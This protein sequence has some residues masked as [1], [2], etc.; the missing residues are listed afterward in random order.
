MLRLD[1]IRTASSVLAAL[2][3]DVDPKPNTYWI[4]GQP[5]VVNW[6]D[7]NFYV[8]NIT[9]GEN[10][11]ALEKLPSVQSKLVTTVSS[12][13]PE[14]RLPRPATSD[15]DLPCTEVE[16]VNMA[17]NA[18]AFHVHLRLFDIS[19][20]DAPES[21][22]VVAYWD[23]NYITLLPLE[24]RILRVSYF[25]ITPVYFQVFTVL[26]F[27][28]S[29]DNNVPSLASSRD[30]RSFQRRHCKCHRCCPGSAQSQVNL[31]LHTGGRKVPWRWCPL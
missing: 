9:S 6:E 29:G 4:S 15:V 18:V 27:F 30:C 22:S 14:G 5:D 21:E 11:T 16:V 25:Y 10:F 7:C 20:G 3:D 23:D 1:L 31:S 24:S 2:Y 13:C 12:M 19:Q 8:C 17:N 26:P 28:I